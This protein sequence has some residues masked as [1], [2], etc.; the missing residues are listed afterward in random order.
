MQKIIV[1]AVCLLLLLCGCTKSDNGDTSPR[2]FEDVSA[3]V[4]ENETVLRQEVE[5]FE[6]GAESSVEGVTAPIE[7]Y[8]QMLRF[9]C[10]YGGLSVSDYEC[11]FYYSPDDIP[12]NVWIGMDELSEDGEGFS[13]KSTYD[14]YTQKICDNFFYYQKID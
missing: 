6:Y 7:E 13:H 3:L 2:S 10:D 1:Y 4:L 5:D 12:F 14:Y 9:R 8:G 11:G